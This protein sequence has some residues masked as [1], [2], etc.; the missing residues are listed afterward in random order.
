MAIN[1]KFQREGYVVHLVAQQ[2]FDRSGDLSAL[3]DRDVDVKIPMGRGDEFA[4]GSPGSPDSKDRPRPVPE[5]RDT[6]VR[7][8]HID[9]LKVR[10]RNFL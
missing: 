7:D 8:L 3:A 4:H 2:L 9:T 6:L 5:A 1:G 10:A